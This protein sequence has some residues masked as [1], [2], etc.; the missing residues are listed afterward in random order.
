MSRREI[1][2]RANAEGIVRVEVGWDRPLE[3]FFAQAFALDAEGHED[4]V[5]WKGSFPREL[6]TPR[7]AIAIIERFCEIPDG[8]VADL[9]TD[10]LKTL[11]TYDG[12]AQAAAKRAL[13]KGELPMRHP[14]TPED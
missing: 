5:I 13:I 2:L 9:E 11:A 6:P 7:S 14:M 8:L 1:P 12:P 10:R 3:T 4:A